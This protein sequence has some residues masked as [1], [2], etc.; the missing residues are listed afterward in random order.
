MK[1]LCAIAHILLLNAINM[2]LELNFPNS[3]QKF[4]MGGPYTGSLIINGRS[5]K[6]EFLDNHYVKS[7]NDDYWG[8]VRFESEITQR[9]RFFGLI[10]SNFYTNKQFRIL[11]FKNTTKEWFVSRNSWDALYLIGIKGS[12]VFYTKAF[13]NSNPK[14]FPE[15]FLEI[16]ESNF[17]IVKENEIYKIEINN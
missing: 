6:Y 5:L 4:N 3:T 8:F 15:L 13:H 14:L 12:K 9:K 11:I 16:D 7:E 10:T 17:I 2:N 1:G